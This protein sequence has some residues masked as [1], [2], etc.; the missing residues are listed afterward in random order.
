M[1]VHIT[2]SDYGRVQEIIGSIGI[3]WKRARYLLRVRE[4]LGCEQGDYLQVGDDFNRKDREH[5]IFDEVDRIENHCLK[6]THY[7]VFGAR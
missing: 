6:L 7:L 5:V 4:I 1:L 2:T 3:A